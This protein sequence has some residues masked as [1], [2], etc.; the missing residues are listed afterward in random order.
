MNQ[1]K[2]KRYQRWFYKSRIEF[3]KKALRNLTFSGYKFIYGVFPY[4][5]KRDYVV[6]LTAAAGVYDGSKPVSSSET[7][8]VIHETWLCFEHNPKLV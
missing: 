7:L 4:D 2:K 3:G 6:K 8:G 1:N 5:L